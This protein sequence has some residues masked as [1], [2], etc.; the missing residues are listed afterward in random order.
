MP[1]RG[2][3]AILP[4]AMPEDR[5][6]HARFT[7][8]AWTDVLAARGVST[9]RSARAIE[10]LCRK[11]WKPVY[12]YLRRRGRRPEEA[13]D[14][15]QD[16]FA[17][18][19]RKSYFAGAD[20]ERG[21]FRTYVLATLGRFL[22]GHRPARRRTREKSLDMVR[23]EELAESARLSRDIEAAED[24]EELYCREWARALVAA[25]LE[26]LKAEHRD[27]K[28]RRYVEVFSAQVESAAAGKA[29]SYAQ[30]AERFDISETDVTNYLHRGRRLYDAALRAELRGSV[31]SDREVE[32]ELAELRH[33][34]GF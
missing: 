2:G 26:R 1:R 23:P 8:T 9:E 25:A 21:K 27:T 10:E 16:Y 33:Y 19:L 29:A 20:R 31:A 13:A 32:E 15:V 7:T 22:S 18:A 5:W 14:L 12:A 34:L 11:Y 6:T 3:A 30:L 17:E 24:P 28:R 4:V